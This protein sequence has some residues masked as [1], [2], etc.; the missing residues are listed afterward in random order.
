LPSAPR[1]SGTFSFD[2]D[3][4]FGDDNAISASLNANYKGST[5]MNLPTV[6][7]RYPKIPSYWLVNAYVGWTRGPVTASL[8]ARNLFDKRAIYAVNTRIT[9]FAPIDLYETVG[10]PRTLGV[11]LEYR[12]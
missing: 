9:A 11:E 10:R 8:Y 7:A 3:R 4:E 12:W 1:H 5:R 6:G 2:Y